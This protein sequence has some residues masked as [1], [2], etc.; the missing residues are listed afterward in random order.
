MASDLAPAEAERARTALLRAIEEA[1]RDCHGVHV[2][3]DTEA[4]AE[5]LG[6]RGLFPRVQ[7]QF[8]WANAGYR[9]FDDW[10]ATFPSDKRNKLR[11]ERKEVAGLRFEVRTPDEADLRALHRFYSNTAEQFGPWGNV[12][13]P[14]GAFVH[15]GRVWGDRLQTV[16]AYDGD[17]RVAGTFNVRKGD[18]L[19]GRYWG[20]DEGV[21]FLHF[22]V[23]YYRPIEYCIAEGISVFEPG[24]GGTHKYRR[25]F[26]P[27]V[28]WSNHRL[29]DP[30]LHA[31]L[32]Q[33]TDAERRHV[34]EALARERQEHGG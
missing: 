13:L 29:R 4:E 2:L 5:W 3:F 7:T 19:Y 23:C 20:C 9:T 1:A 16:L 15:L 28:T 30:R 10:L 21:K 26:R 34:F 22:E 25:G 12:Y 17:R 8:H 24:H 14:E 11:R 31:A 33:H 27:T 6:A 32:A 18:R